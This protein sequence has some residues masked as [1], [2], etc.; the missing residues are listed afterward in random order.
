MLSELD[1]ED[2]RALDALAGVVDEGLDLAEQ[3]GWRYALAYLIS[4]RVPPNVIQRLLSG[5]GRV[6]H[7][8]SQNEP[9]TVFHD[10]VLAGRGGTAMKCCDCSRR[11]GS[12]G[13]LSR[14][15]RT[16]YRRH[17]APACLSTRKIDGVRGPGSKKG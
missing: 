14:A 7:K 17:L 16:M 5:G 6:R 12:A 4:E 3:C 1:I 8:R 13:L 2:R 15:G 11:S 9:G 10:T